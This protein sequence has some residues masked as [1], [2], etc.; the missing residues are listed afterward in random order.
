[1][2]RLQVFLRRARYPRDLDHQLPAGRSGRESSSS[3]RVWELLGPLPKGGIVGVIS[4]SIV[5]LAVPLL[6]P[7]R[8]IKTTDGTGTYAFYPANSKRALLPRIRA[9]LPTCCQGSAGECSLCNWRRCWPA[10]ALRRALFAGRASRGRAL[11][12]LRPTDKA[13][14]RYSQPR[15][16]NTARSI[17]GGAYHPPA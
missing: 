13:A 5:P 1:M 17:P 6:Q 12:G 10:Q 16:P 15:S 8:T 3:C 14:E 4:R 7:C 9:S 2:L 11:R